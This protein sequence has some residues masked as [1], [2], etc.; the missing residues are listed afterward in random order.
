MARQCINDEC[1][2]EAGPFVRTEDG[3]VC[4]DCAEAKKD[5]Q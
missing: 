2:D 4:E 1:R 3:W 5:E